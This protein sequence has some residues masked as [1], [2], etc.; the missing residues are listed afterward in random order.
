MVKPLVGITTNAIFISNIKT[1]RA[2]NRNKG[3]NNMSK[4]KITI[5]PYD[6]RKKIWDFIHQGKTNHQIVEEVFKEAESCMVSDAKLIKC[7]SAN[8]NLY[9]RGIK[10][11]PKSIISSLGRSGQISFMQGLE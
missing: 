10:P 6:L 4:K 8:R 11:N 9:A 3:G 2:F 5:L 7:I 1:A